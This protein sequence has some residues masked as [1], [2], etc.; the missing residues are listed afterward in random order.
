MR[1]NNRLGWA[2]I[3]L[4]GGS[5][6]LLG[7]CGLSDQQ[8]QAVWQSVITSTLTSSVDVLLTT[9]AQNATQTP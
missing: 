2:R 3:L 7:N 5:L 1:K 9:V 8:L 6:F 4:A